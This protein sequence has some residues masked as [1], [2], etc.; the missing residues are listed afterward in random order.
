MREKIWYDGGMETLIIIIIAIYGALLSTVLMVLKTINFLHNRPVV[1]VDVSWMWVRQNDQSH[2]LLWII[3]AINIGRRRIKFEDAGFTAST[4]W[5]LL[6]MK[7]WA[8][9]L[10][11]Q[12]TIKVD[13]DGSH[14]KKA[15]GEHAPG[16]F[17]EFGW[18][19]DITGKYYQDRIPPD[20]TEMLNWSFDG[21]RVS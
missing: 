1:R 7:D 13:F 6:C 17:I 4:G 10:D 12:D 3:K 2:K 18:F 5:T 20:M 16:S 8:A 15:L 14:L 21:P 11:E 19:K 9:I